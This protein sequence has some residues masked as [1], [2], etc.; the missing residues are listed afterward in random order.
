MGGGGTTVLFAVAKDRTNAAGSFILSEEKILQ[1]GR[2]GVLAV[3]L[4][5]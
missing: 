4:Q 2:G 5:S 1:I 3:G